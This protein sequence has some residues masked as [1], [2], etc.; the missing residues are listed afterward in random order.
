[1][2]WCTY[3][4]WSG[5]AIGQIG[6]CELKLSSGNVLGLAKL[7]LFLHRLAFL[8]MVVPSC[9]AAERAEKRVWMLRA[10]WR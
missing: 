4:T 10:L 2:H 5:D 7:G 8:S 1:M 9:P 6:R 3:S